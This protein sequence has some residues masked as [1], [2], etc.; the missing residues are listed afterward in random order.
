MGFIHDKQAAL[1]PE[2]RK[3]PVMAGINGP[4]ITIAQ[5]GPLLR[6]V[7]GV[8]GW[9]EKVLFIQA[10]VRSYP[11]AGGAELPGTAGADPIEWGTS[12]LNPMR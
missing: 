4:D 6:Q 2:S 10:I 3:Q 9:A 1:V 12:G 5:V 11:E 7:I 8:V